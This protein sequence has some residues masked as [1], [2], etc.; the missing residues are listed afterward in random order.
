MA[1]GPSLKQLII[2]NKSKKKVKGK[3]AQNKDHPAVAQDDY[4]TDMRTIETWAQYVQNQLDNIT[5]G[6]GYASLTGPG[7]TTTPGALTQN[8]DLTVNDDLDVSGTTNLD[9]LDGGGSISWSTSGSVSFSSNGDF[10]ASSAG[11]AAIFG[12][13]TASL[14]SNDNILIE[15]T[16]AGGGGSHA[17]T[18][19]YLS[20]GVGSLTLDSNGAT[21]DSLVSG[22]TNIFSA[23]EVNI[24]GFDVIVNTIHTG[25]FGRF[26]VL[27]GNNAEMVL[28]GRA[29]DPSLGH[30]SLALTL[31][32]SGG[33]NSTVQFF[34]AQNL[35]GLPNLS[36]SG[37]STP[38]FGFTQS[39]HIYFNVGNSATWNLLV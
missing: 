11:N 33:S 12:T 21:L 31:D 38:A 39:G 9:A 14:E 17:V 23:N 26:F 37:G 1:V 27:A 6:A 2:P 3:T 5:P 4:S 30:G 28:N 16:T 8:G 20:T 13:V 15:V 36:V 22:N 25:N 32:P 10:D 34:T 24:N 7:E 18:L 35:A 19:Q 29:T